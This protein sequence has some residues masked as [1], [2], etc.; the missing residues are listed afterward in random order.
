[1][2]LLGSAATSGGGSHQNS[3]SV[4]ESEEPSAGHATGLTA[5]LL[6]DGAEGEVGEE[7]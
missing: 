3:G 5:P 4:S 1:M 7:R 6:P 2:L